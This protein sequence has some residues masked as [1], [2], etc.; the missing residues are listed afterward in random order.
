[1]VHIDEAEPSS[2]G[3]GVI[4]TQRWKQENEVRQRDVG[5]EDETRKTPAGSAP[6]RTYTNQGW[7]GMNTK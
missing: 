4:Q 7:R 6:L 3:A 5:V 1:M 2:W